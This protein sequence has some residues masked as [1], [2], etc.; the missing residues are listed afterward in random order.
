[1]KTLLKTLLLCAALAVMSGCS[2]QKRAERHVRKAVELCP[3]LVQTKAHLIDTVLTVPGFADIAAV[4]LSAILQYDNIYAATDHGTVMVSLRPSDSALRVGF[5]AA[6]RQI[7]YRDTLNYAQVEIVR[8][9]RP[10]DNGWGEFVI[11][12][13]CFIGGIAMALY[14][15]FR[16]KN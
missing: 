9:A 11:G 16:K 12:V 8:Q 2:A 4:P 13:A 6:P 7:P 10:S 5:V 1:M 15:L 14:L 3:E